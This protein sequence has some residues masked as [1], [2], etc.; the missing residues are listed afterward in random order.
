MSFYTGE[1]SKTLRILHIDITI[2]SKTTLSTFFV[3]D[4]TAN[5]NIFLRRVGF[6]PIGVCRPL[7]TSSYYFGRVMKWKWFGQISNP[8]W[9]LQVLWKSSIMIRNSVRSSSLEEGKM[10]SQGKHTW[11]QRALPKSKRKRPNS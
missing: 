9:R 6:M 2:G 1:V 11:T 4:S 3:I 8:S 10:G 7:F 5:Y